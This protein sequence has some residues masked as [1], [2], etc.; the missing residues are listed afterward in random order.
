MMGT[1][2]RLM[3]SRILVLVDAGYAVYTACTL[4]E[5]QQTLRTEKVDL[6]ILCQSLTPKQCS[7]ALAIMGE[8]RAEIP[9]L[10]LQ[11]SIGIPPKTIRVVLFDG[12]VWPRELLATVSKLA[13]RQEVNQAS[14]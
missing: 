10:S 1:D 13:N 2:L 11:P 8:L 14:A 12:L 3:E 7:E 5:F 9:V 4:N 6:C